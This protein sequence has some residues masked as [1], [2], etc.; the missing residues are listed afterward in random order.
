MTDYN[1]AGLNTRSFEQLIQAIAVKVFGPDIIIFGDGPDG[2]RE[3]TFEGVVPYPSKEHAWNGYGVVQ[4][5]FLQRPLGAPKD[6]EWALQQLRDEIAKF[7]PRPRTSQGVKAKR[8]AKKPS[9]VRKLSTYVRRVPDYYVFVTNAVL[10]PVGDQ[11]TKDKVKSVLEEFK[12][13]AGLKGFDIWDYD[14]ICSYLDGYEDIRHGYEGFITTGDVLAHVI[15]WL[16]PHQPNFEQVMYRFL[17]EELIADQYANLEQAG[18]AT[19][20]KVPIARVFVDLPAYDE[21]MVASPVEAISE[22]SHLPPGFVAE[23]VETAK[24]RLDPSSVKANISA[25]DDRGDASQ[26]DLG[27]F[28]LVGGP[29]QGKT[30][31]SQFICQLFR[32]SILKGRS[33]WVPVREVQDILDLIDAQCDSEGIEL[34]P[35]R[36]F[37]IRIVLNE[38]AKELATTGPGHPTSVLSYLAARIKKR[39]DEEVTTGDLRLW[40]K[41]YPWLVIFD[42]LDEVPASSNRGAILKAIQSFR[43]EINEGNADVLIIATTRPQGYSGDFAPGVYRHKWLVPLSITRALHYAR[44]LARIRYA[45]DSDRRDRV[46]SRLERAANSE[47]TARLMRSPLQVTIMTTLVGTRGQPPQERWSLF[48]EYY[49][50]IYQRETEREIP[51]SQ[52]LQEYRSD[53]DRIHQ[54]VGLILQTKSERSGETDA[55]LSRQDFETVVADRL[56]EEGHEG[57]ERDDLQRQITEAATDRLVFLVGL[58]DDQVGFEIRSLQ[59]F[60][61]A[62]ALMDGREDVVRNRL[63]EIAPISNWRNVFLFA[64]GKC[65]AERQDLRDTIHTICAELNDSVADEVT[66][67]TLEGSQLAAD[68]LEEGVVRTQPKYARLLTRLAVRALSL[69]PAPIHQRLANLYDP[70]FDTLYRDE[71]TQHFESSDFYR[72]LGAWDCLTRLMTSGIAWAQLLGDRYWPAIDDQKMTVL[73]VTAGIKDEGWKLPKLIETIPRF[74]LY[75]IEARRSREGDEFILEHV[76]SDAAPEWFLAIKYLAGARWSSAGTLEVPIVISESSGHMVTLKL[77]K[78]MGR[79][80]LASAFVGMPAEAHQGWCPILA[81]AR[82]QVD[83]TRQT[84]ARELRTLAATDDFD[85]VKQNS[86]RLPWVLSACISVA[87][88]GKDLEQLADRAEN[89]DLGDRGDWVAAEKRWSEEGI[90]SADIE[91]GSAETLPFDKHIAERGFPF[92]AVNGW[93]TSGWEKKDAVFELIRLHERLPPSRVRCQLAAWTVF[94]LASGARR[95]NSLSA[96]KVVTGTQ[97][98]NLIRDA[99]SLKWVISLTAL[100]ACAWKAELDASWIEVLDDI[101]R[102]AYLHSNDKVNQRLIDIVSKA[103]TQYPDRA[104]LLTVLSLLVVPGGRSSVPADLLNPDRY[105]KAEYR[106]AAIITRVTQVTLALDEVER[107]AKYAAADAGKEGG[108]G[109]NVFLFMLEQNRLPI[110]STT[111]RFCIALLRNLPSR[112]WR[113]IR[114]TINA[115]SNSLKRRRSGLEL[116]EVWSRLEFRPK[117]LSLV[118]SDGNT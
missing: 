48:S 103:F 57:M 22:T 20:D 70:A 71:L 78:L 40:L 63:R 56:N 54:R 106:A 85:T 91:Q 118:Q 25:R 8:S 31:V 112:N 113:I 44:R 52:I 43:L 109:A 6:G 116:N 46:L 94:A 61:A 115:L 42:G 104:G 21:Q 36:R 33:N 65:F 111:D 45:A 38:F 29:G 92:I 72:S 117:L 13:E 108:W 17:Q 102:A 86:G 16:R 1:L 99:I 26:H 89:G 101:G 11:G 7:P 76:N 81:A 73:R 4:A 53:I 79:T 98:L 10:T 87:E 80:D 64:A 55:R 3:A 18:R 90:R 66:S 107:Y 58:Q 50:V 51:A 62:E 93:S 9:T 49:K 32:A 69:V 59:E 96:D 47:A 23:V 2:G 60:M 35:T 95:S 77:D 24:I 88:C 110:D 14:K 41:N 82:L 12:R 28:V 34:P 74:P 67:A 83:P 75:K 39:T 5:K 68:L 27:R 97:L 100:N 84:L 105:E 15:E 30:T 114:R 37:P 19:E